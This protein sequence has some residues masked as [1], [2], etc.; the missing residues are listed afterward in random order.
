MEDDDAADEKEEKIEAEGEGGQT[1][2]SAA[3]QDAEYEKESK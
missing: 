2:E 3:K 1:D